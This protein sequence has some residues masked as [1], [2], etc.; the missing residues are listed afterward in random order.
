MESPAWLGGKC[1]SKGVKPGLT[2]KLA[3]QWRY[4]GICG[5]SQ[6]CQMVPERSLQKNLF[7]S[8]LPSIAIN[9]SFTLPI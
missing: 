7:F 9:I 1:L 6:S 8:I 2:D 3:D 5:V 4:F